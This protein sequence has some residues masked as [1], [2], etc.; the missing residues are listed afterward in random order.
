MIPPE[1]GASPDPARP[2]KGAKFPPFLLVPASLIFLLLLIELPALVGLVRY[3][4]IIG[5]ES[6][7][8]F[9]ATN[10]GDPELLHL[11]PP[12]SHFSGS[13]R[14]GNITAGYRIPASEMTLYQWDAHYDQNGF[15]NDRDLKSAGIAVIGDSFVEELTIPDAQLMTTLLAKSEN[16]VVANLG[17]YGYGPL[18]ELGVLRRY[19]LSLE[20]RTVI[21]M[22]FEGNDLKDVIHYRR[23]TAEEHAPA[24]FWRAF[25]E[26]SFTYNA[27]A[28][29]HT[30]AKRALKP[31]GIARAGIFEAPN[32]SKTT[33]YFIYSS[34]PYTQDDL[35]A[36]E[37][38]DHT[39]TSAH[40]LCAAQGAR[41]LFVFVP[42]KFRV[43]R[44]FCRFPPESE[45]RNWGLN[46]MPERLR[47]AVQAISPEIGYLDL[48][49]G[50]VAAAKGGALPYFTDDDHWSPEGNTVATEAIHDYLSSW[51]AR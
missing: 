15:R 40:R 32:G 19:A 13:A 11:H 12:H 50:L 24:S 27:L 6:G 49:P 35:S 21:W 37:E 36:L 3:Q 34:G 28:Q 17:Q 42:T 31:S 8:I 1:N 2:S 9:A 25:W 44:S 23:A 16:Q 10:R 20:P 33:L 47:Q 38:T 14:G 39:I 30:Q 43:F 22:F 18:E 5:P 41:L 4:K 26:R 48:T 7:D 45:C 29:V 51:Q 46:D